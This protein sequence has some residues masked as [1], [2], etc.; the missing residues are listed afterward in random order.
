MDR[1]IFL[2]ELS[3]SVNF[4]TDFSGSVNSFDQPSGSVNFFVRTFG[5]GQF[6]D[7]ESENKK[8]IYSFDTLCDI[9]RYHT[10]IPAQ[11]HFKAWTHVLARSKSFTLDKELYFIPLPPFTMDVEMLTRKLI[12]YNV[13]KC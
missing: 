2:S 9:L 3:G 8:L 11:Q 6:F 12:K 10:R 5:V 13:S 4:L 7:Q 1:S